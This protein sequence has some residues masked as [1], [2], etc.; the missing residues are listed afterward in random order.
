MECENKQTNATSKSTWRID[1]DSTDNN[2]QPFKNWPSRHSSKMSY[3]KV[4]TYKPYTV[5]KNRFQLLDNLQAEDS[6]EEVPNETP[7]PGKNYSSAIRVRSARA[8]VTKVTNK[9]QFL[10]ANAIPVI[11]RG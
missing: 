11:V 1:T 7:Q 5:T 10:N 9:T 8:K 2:V 4:A 3:Y 6:P